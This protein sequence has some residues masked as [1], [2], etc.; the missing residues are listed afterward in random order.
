MVRAGVRVGVRV[1]VR[2][3]ARVRVRVECLRVGCAASDQM[4]ECVVVPLTLAHLVG[5]R[6]G[7]G[8]WVGC[9]S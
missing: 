2:A 6:L 3:T 9:W 5:V 4:V 7:V 1:R 8:A